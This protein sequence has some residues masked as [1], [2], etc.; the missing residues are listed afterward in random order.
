MSAIKNTLT[1]LLLLLA[2]L[3]GAVAQAATTP[4]QKAGGDKTEQ[5]LQLK[6]QGL[7]RM[8]LQDEGLEAIYEMAGK[9]AAAIVTS[10]MQAELGRELTVSESKSLEKV[11]INSIRRAF[12]PEDWVLAV[13][14][15]YAKYFS[16]EELDKLADFYR[17]PV[18]KK[19]IRLQGNIVRESGDA[20]EKL[21]EANAERFVEIFQQEMEKEFGKETDKAKQQ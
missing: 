3:A 8:M 9:T 21:F 13:A 18:G 4:A 12:A 19:T 10:S 1:T 17:T 20:G 6:A 7:V 5:Q 16:S 14:P 15:V 2:L 11:V